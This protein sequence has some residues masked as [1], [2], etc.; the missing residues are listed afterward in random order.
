M[1]K[2]NRVTTMLNVSDIRKSLNFYRNV[3]GFELETPEEMVDEW[4]WAYISQ[5]EARLMLANAAESADD[6]NYKH[7][8][9]QNHWPAIHYFYPE[10]VM[11]LHAY[12][13]DHEYSPSELQVTFAGMREFWMRDPDGHLLVFGEET[14]EMSSAA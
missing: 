12:L 3:L 4:R 1:I 14:T 2:I 8:P 11:E 5:G 10:S 6:L 9:E 13:K 7:S